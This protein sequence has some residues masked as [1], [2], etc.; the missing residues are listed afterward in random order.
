MPG[1]R[2][3]KSSPDIESVRSIR[4]SSGFSGPELNVSAHDLALITKGRNQGRIVSVRIF[5]GENPR[6]MDN[7]YFPNEGPYWLILSKSSNLCAETVSAYDKSV[8]ETIEGT[9]MPFPDSYLQRLV[10]R[11]LMQDLEN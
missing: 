6:W 4:E 8:W 7:L 3:N 11:E 2:S 10:S 5:L 1:T 9:L